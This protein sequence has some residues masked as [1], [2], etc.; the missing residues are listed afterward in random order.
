[1]RESEVGIMFIVWKRLSRR[2]HAQGRIL[3][4][5]RWD[6][7]VCA[8]CPAYTTVSMG[9][10]EETPS[11]LSNYCFEIPQPS[12]AVSGHGDGADNGEADFFRLRPHKRVLL[13]PTLTFTLPV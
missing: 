6:A 3:G 8:P 7:R 1:M 13:A 2:E 9:V 10:P 11:V 5:F 12:S 4:W